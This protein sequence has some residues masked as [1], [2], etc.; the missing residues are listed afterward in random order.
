MVSAD[1]WLKSQLSRQ[2]G[3][4]PFSSSPQSRRSWGITPETFQ[5]YPRR[6]RR[7]KTAAA[8]AG[9]ECDVSTSQSND[10]GVS[11]KRFKPST[12]AG[13]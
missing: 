2:N 3:S 5:N 8:A 7:R 4:L 13:V 9:K 12:P 6:N 10:F 1:N 11:R